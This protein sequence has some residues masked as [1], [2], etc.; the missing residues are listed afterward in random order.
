MTVI[1]M[2]R[3]FFIEFTIFMFREEPFS[4]SC[5]VHCEMSTTTRVHPAFSQWILGC[6]L[7]GEATVA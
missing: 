1:N 2:T 7:G 4:S 5:A 3:Y 6:T